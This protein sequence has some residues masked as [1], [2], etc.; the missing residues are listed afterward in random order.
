MEA[1]ADI[2]MEEV[3][4]GIAGLTRGAASAVMPLVQRVSAGR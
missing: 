3:V 1:L 2:P 4:M